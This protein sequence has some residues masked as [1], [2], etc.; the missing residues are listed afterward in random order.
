MN[1]YAQADLAQPIRL[2]PTIEREDSINQV[3]IL[4]KLY[5]TVYYVGELC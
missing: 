1:Y 4:S 3:Q 5:S 2:I